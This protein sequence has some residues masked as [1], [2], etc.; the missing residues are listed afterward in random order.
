MYILG[1][2]ILGK[3]FRQ[4]SLILNEDGL[5]RLI[6]VNGMSERIFLTN[7]IHKILELLDLKLEDLDN[8]IDEDAFIQLVA[9]PYFRLD[10]FMGHE[11]ERSRELETFRLF[12]LTQEKHWME[13]PNRFEAIRTERLE[14]VLG[15]ELRSKFDRMKI[16]LTDFPHQ[17]KRK[18]NGTKALLIESGYNPQNFSKDIP[19]FYDS[20]KTELEVMEFFVDGTIQDIVDR[21]NMT[22]KTPDLPISYL[23]ELTLP[24]LE[25]E[26]EELTKA[27]KDIEFFHQKIGKIDFLI[28]QKEKEIKALKKLQ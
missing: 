12:L 21:F 27:K 7:D 16:I 18:F 14:K 6:Q 4:S 3:N 10:K 9:C 5:Y 22:C 25:V 11:V 8:K 26:K 17:F 28:K 1:N 19:K 20:F 2:P 23:D 15:L 13:R 24:L